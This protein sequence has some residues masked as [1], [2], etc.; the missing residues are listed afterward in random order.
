MIQK[1]NT[2]KF[3]IFRKFAL[4]A[5]KLKHV[6]FTSTFYMSVKIL[7]T[8]ITKQHRVSKTPALSS[9][10][11]YKWLDN[12]NEYELDKCL[13]GTVSH[14]GGHLIQTGGKVF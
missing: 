9:E 8:E 6:E 1:Q 4:N 13:H 10:R 3:E 11:D 12:D 5:K 14:K 2:I 7:G